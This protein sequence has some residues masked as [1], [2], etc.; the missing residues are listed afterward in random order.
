M[1]VLLIF[2][3]LLAALIHMDSTVATWLMLT[4]QVALLL[5]QTVRGQVTGTGSF[6]FLSLLFFGIRPIYIVTE[7]DF[8]LFHRLFFIDVDLLAVNQNMLWATLAMIVFWLG[9]ASND[10]RKQRIAESEENASENT[11]VPHAATN[12]MA[13]IFLLFQII[14]LPFMIY[15]AGSGRALYSSSFGAYAYDL[16]VPLQSIHIIAIL[17]ILERYLDRRE[18]AHFGSLIL[19]SLLFLAF[20][21]YMR[22]VSMFRGFY[23]GGV[24][25]AGIAAIMRLRGRVSYLWLIL[26]ILLVQPFFRSLGETRSLSNIEIQE[27]SI[28][29][30]SF[31]D[32][33]PTNAYWR[34][35]DSKGDMNIFDTFVAARA[36]APETTPYILSWLYAPVH[37]IPR[38]IWSSKPERGV[39]HDVSFTNG[40]P[41]SPGIAGFFWLD[42]GNDYW[43]L[44]SMF[45]L[46]MIIGRLDRKVLNM[47]EG[48]LRNALL[49]ILV[50][51]CM[52]LTRFF[53]WQAFWQALYAVIPC[54]LL[55][56][57]LAPRNQEL[58]AGQSDNDLKKRPLS[59]DTKAPAR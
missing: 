14:S 17:V 55:H 40:A 19:S 2:L 22:E 18:A 48:Y 4:S 25:I 49:A 10:P 46:G 45:G 37:I 32:E 23:I 26:P 15:L 39:L 57:L 30:K 42:G 6:I 41:Y 33:K 31:G 1:F 50:V 13:R 43:L 21:W 7:N 5:N 59:V 36:S 44:A 56:Y 27:L 8:D 20:T 11:P 12:G 47:R 58:T 24:M 3:P 53:L 16:P 28:L 9:S 51:N 29:E 34:F 52:F 38:A 54:F 35:Y